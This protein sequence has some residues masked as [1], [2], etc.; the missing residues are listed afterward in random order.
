[1]GIGCAARR[2]FPLNFSVLRVEDSNKLMNRTVSSLALT[3]MVCAVAPAASIPTTLTVNATAALGV[4]GATISGTASFTGGIGSGTISATV[5]LSALIADP[6][7]TTFTITGLTGGNLTGN[8]SVPQPIQTG[9]AT[10]SAIESV[11][12][13]IRHST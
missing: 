13:T 11:T 12:V 8:V 4:S 7:T 5:P 1:M 3:L 6:A 10:S 9:D 2:K